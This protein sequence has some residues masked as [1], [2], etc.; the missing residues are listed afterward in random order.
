M[1]YYVQWNLQI[2]DT[3]GPATLSSVERLSSSR[4]LEMNYCYGKGSRIASFVGRLSLSTV[5]A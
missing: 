4:R 2:K 1:T 3:L 5:H